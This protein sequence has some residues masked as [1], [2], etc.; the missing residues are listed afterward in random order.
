MKTPRLLLL[1]PAILL[2]GFLLAPLALAVDTPSK[3]LNISSRAN[4]GTGNRV[5][6]A[7]FIIQGDGKDILVRGI[8]PSLQ[9]NG[10]PLAGR[11][12]DP[13]LQLFSGGTTL[14]SNNNWKDSQQTQIEATG[15][16]PSNDLES[17]IVH[18]FAAGSYTTILRGNNSTQGIGVIELY[19][20]NAGSTAALRNLSTRGYVGTGDNLV[21][22]GFIVGGGSGELRLL[23]RLLG[24][25]L[26]QVGITDALQDPM[27]EVFNANGQLIGQN[28]NWQDDQQFQIQ[29]TG[30]A[31][32]NTLEAAILTSLL[33]GTYT[34]VARG[35]NATSGTALLEVYQVPEP[36]PTQ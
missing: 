27:V 6:I 28:N 7:G 2:A 26:S 36:P 12:A 18:T 19:D 9:I 15:A 13:T 3:L 16:A 31:P 17:A 5:A 34:A 1:L 24:P 30:L 11:L 4:V 32:P 8:G 22:S 14:A 10:V 29:Q 25:S 35:L 23:V 21:I 20:L 33:P